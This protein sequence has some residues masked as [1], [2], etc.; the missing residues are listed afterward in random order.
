MSLSIDARMWLNH[1]ATVTWNGQTA[2]CKLGFCLSQ[3]LFHQKAGIGD[4]F[5]KSTA[6]VKK[7][8]TVLFPDRQYTLSDALERWGDWR[9]AISPRGCEIFLCERRPCWVWARTLRLDSVQRP[10]R[11]DLVS[12]EGWKCNLANMYCRETHYGAKLACLGRKY[13]IC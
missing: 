12:S 11:A 8:N 4:Y 7:N 9:A 5:Y 1:V 10:D 2:E 6:W 13:G 3:L